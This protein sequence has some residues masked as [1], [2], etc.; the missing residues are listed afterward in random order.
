MAATADLPQLTRLECFLHL[1]FL[2]RLSRAELARADVDASAG[3][4]HWFERLAAESSGEQLARVVDHSYFFLPHV[5]RLLFPEFDGMKDQSGSELQ[6]AV[7]QQHSNASQVRASFLDAD[8]DGRLQNCTARLT[9]SPTES[10]LNKELVLQS[11]A[12]SAVHFRIDWIDALLFP[13]HIGVLLL[14]ITTSDPLDTGDAASFLRALRKSR[15]RRRLTVGVP[16][17]LDSETQQKHSWGDLVDSAIR[18]LESHDHDAV[19]LVRETFGTTFK[20][21]VVTSVEGSTPEA[22][23]EETRDDLEV[24]AFSLGTGHAPTTAVDM[25]TSEGMSALRRDS[26]L[27]SWE[28]WRVLGYDEGVTVAL[29]TGCDDADGRALSDAAHNVHEIAEWSYVLAHILCTVQFV[30]LH[31]LFRDLASISPS[32]RD[33]LNAIEAFEGQFVRYRQVLWHTEATSAPAGGAVYALCRSVY[34]LD[35]LNESLQSDIDVMRS[36]LALRRERIELKNAARTTTVLEF[37]TFV[38]VPVGIILTVLQVATDA[39][40]GPWFD[41]RGWAAVVLV[42]AV[43][44][45]ATA[46]FVGFKR[47]SRDSD[48]GEL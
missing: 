35:Q 15:N 2:H 13:Q 31:L 30:R 39:V 14:K 34:R 48:D 37:L 40:I 32:L 43:W 26:M 5:R 18:P 36:H 16:D 3:W 29:M 19:Q 33:A 8:S 24:T 23:I 22:S 28:N 41:D 7:E 27:A 25:Y 42:L 20:S 1:P 21:L 45:G 9:W 44:I 38:G 6:R 10:I 47:A 46:A 17:V 12:N 11:S 4:C